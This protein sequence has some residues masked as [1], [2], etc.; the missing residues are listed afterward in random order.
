MVENAL[1]IL[2][3]RWRTYDTRARGGT[4]SLPCGHAHPRSS[5]ELVMEKVEGRGIR[6]LP[7]SG[8]RPE[9]TVLRSGE[10][11]TFPVLNQEHLLIPHVTSPT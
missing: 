1:D 4:H 6:L 10:L 5:T 8:Q 3:Q 9:K 11:V 7:R 2:A